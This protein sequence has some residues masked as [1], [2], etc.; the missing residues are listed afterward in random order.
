MSD[1]K[2]P[3]LPPLYFWRIKR[4]W[5]GLVRVSIRK[6]TWAGSKA[7]RTEYVVPQDDYEKNKRWI[8]ARAKDA[9]HTY[10]IGDGIEM[11]VGD[12]GA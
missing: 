4:D 8:E 12:Y 10:F 3:T 5:D 6:K 11:L 2:L 1:L 7:V 9:Y